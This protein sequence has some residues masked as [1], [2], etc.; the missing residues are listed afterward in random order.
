MGRQLAR[1]LSTSLAGVPKITVVGVGGAGGNAVNN[2]IERGDFPDHIHFVAAN[3]DAQALEASLTPHRIR[4]GATLTGGLGAGARPEVGRSAAMASYAAI[5]EQ[6]R[7]R[8]MCFITAGMGGGTGTGAAPVIARAAKEAGLLTVAVVSR[9][10]GFEGSKRET[11]A[12]QG[13]EEL[14]PEVDTLVRRTGLEPQPSRLKIDLPLTRASP[15]LDRSWCPTRSCSRWP[16]RT[17]PSPPPSAW[18]TACSCAPCGRSPTSSSPR[19]W[20]TSTLRTCARWD[21]RPRTPV[22]SLALPRPWRPLLDLSPTLKTRT[23]PPPGPS[24][25]ALREQVMRD[26]GLALIGVGEASGEGRAA[27]AL[28]QALTNPLLES[29]DISQA[30]GVLASFS[31]G[32][33]MSLFEVEEAAP[34]LRTAPAQTAPHRAP[35]LPLSPTLGPTLS[36][37]VSA[38]LT[39]WRKHS[40]CCATS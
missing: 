32:Q 24:P 34:L 26:R 7:G 20:S 23:H 38:V 12:R 31:G 8:S 3:T 14:R 33:D 36:P 28:E 16:R 10:F 40:L 35:R 4:L 19:A 2:M 11:L 1:K 18:R 29:T 5:D 25:L 22:L 27:L 21:A 17:P 13:L 6:L 39:R 30:T 9:P 37:T 15:A